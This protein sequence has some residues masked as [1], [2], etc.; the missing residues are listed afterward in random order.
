MNKKLLLS[1]G[2][3]SMAF[4]TACTNAIEPTKTK[5]FI[6]DGAKQCFGGGV[7]KEQTAQKL[8]DDGIQ[9]YDSSCGKIQGMMTIAV[10]GGPTLSINVHTINSEDIKKAEMLGF[11]PVSTLRDGYLEGCKQRTAKPVTH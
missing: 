1:L 11:K 8:K 7:T 9:V 5:V 2:L 3:S 6:N 10:C 4:L